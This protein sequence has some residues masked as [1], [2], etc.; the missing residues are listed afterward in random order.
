M[1][2]FVCWNGSF[3]AEICR[4]VL[5][6]KK[7]V[8]S[9]VVVLEMSEKLAFFETRDLCGAVIEQLYFWLSE[10]LD[11]VHRRKLAKNKFQG[12]AT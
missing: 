5:K 3:I 8:L 12:P 9:T 6:K 4:K 10:M 11:S 1:T 7:T 2:C